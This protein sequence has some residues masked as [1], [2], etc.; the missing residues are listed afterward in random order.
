MITSTLTK[1]SSNVLFKQLILFLDLWTVLKIDTQI[2]VQ[3]YT[4]IVK[5]NVLDSDH[6]WTP[7]WDQGYFWK[8][9]SK[10]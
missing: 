8:T 6:H 4:Y 10:L 7:F 5:I 2:L 3:Y 1:V 9:I